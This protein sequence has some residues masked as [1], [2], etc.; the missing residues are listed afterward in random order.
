MTNSQPHRKP[1]ARQLSYL[2]D[3]AMKTGQSFTYPRT[4][5]EASAAIKRL[6]GVKQPS[7]ANGAERPARSVETWPSAAATR[8]ASGPMRRAA[9]A[10]PP[11]G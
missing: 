11:V 1:T 10:P 9:G 2:K 5:G 6:E 3:L 4:F 8:L 7:R